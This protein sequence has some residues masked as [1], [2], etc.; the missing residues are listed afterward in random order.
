MAT[1]ADHFPQR[2]EV[3]PGEARS[4]RLECSCGHVARGATREAVGSAY[5]AHVLP[6]LTSAGDGARA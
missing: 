5:D 3:V 6:Q 1:K 2:V 4:Y